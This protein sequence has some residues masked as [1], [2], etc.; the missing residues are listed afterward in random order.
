MDYQKFSGSDL[1]S[2]I[3]NLHNISHQQI[4]DL[5]YIIYDLCD[6]LIDHDL[7]RGAIFFSMFQ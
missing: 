7:S 6:L 5:M 4:Q 3:Q 2:N 1:Y